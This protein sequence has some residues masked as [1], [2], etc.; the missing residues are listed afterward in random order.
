MEGKRP[1]GLCSE[2]RTEEGR[3]G[4]G[5]GLRK[6]VNQAREGGALGGL[7]VE[8]FKLGKLAAQKL[9][10]VLLLGC[11]FVRTACVY[12]CMSL[13]SQKPNTQWAIASQRA[14]RQ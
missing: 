5:K 7:A 11:Q 9:L 10:R 14:S 6:A 13:I 4:V 3:V 8:C 2:A 12:V 1:H